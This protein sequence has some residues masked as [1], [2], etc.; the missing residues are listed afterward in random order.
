MPY[1]NE[2]ASYEPL[3]RVA[4]SERVIQLLGRSKVRDVSQ[5]ADTLPQVNFADVNPVNGNQIL[6]LQLTAIIR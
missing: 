1:E 5:D 6:L 4:E 2:F 3:R